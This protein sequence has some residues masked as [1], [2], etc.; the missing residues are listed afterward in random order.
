MIILPD[1]ASLS[2]IIRNRFHHYGTRWKHQRV[3]CCVFFKRTPFLVEHQG[4]IILLA[5]IWLWPS[6]VQ[7]RS[8][9][10]AQTCG[11]HCCSHDYLCCVWGIFFKSKVVVFT[12]R[13][14]SVHA[15]YIHQAKRTL[16]T[17]IITGKKGEHTNK[18]R[19]TQRDC[20]ISKTHPHNLVP[21]WFPPDGDARV[22]HRSVVHPGIPS[23]PYQVRRRAARAR[24]HLVCTTHPPLERVG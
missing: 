14:W 24:L 21:E 16:S 3:V 11:L 15:L 19:C 5:D 17:P 20:G 2:C 22:Q 13:G 1:G 23:L 12:N 18:T 8:H 4:L 10:R 6:R 9:C 7:V